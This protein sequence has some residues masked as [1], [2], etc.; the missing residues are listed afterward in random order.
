MV[1]ILFHLYRC[2]NVLNTKMLFRKKF[3]WL[4]ALILMNLQ[5]EKAELAMKLSVFSLLSTDLQRVVLCRTMQ[6][7]L[8][9][10]TKARGKTDI[11][12]PAALLRSATFGTGIRELPVLSKC[13]AIGIA[14]RMRVSH[15]VP[16]RGAPKGQ[17]V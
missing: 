4:A 1:I 10:A 15:R 6:L 11:P 17:C 8:H 9:G 7:G 14:P 2:C 16:R 12:D 3:A 5:A 13:W